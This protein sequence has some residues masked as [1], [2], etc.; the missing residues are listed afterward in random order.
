MLLNI[1]IDSSRNP[2]SDKIIL[3]QNVVRKFIDDGVEFTTSRPIFLRLT[4]FENSKNGPVKLCSISVSVR[5]FALEDSE[6]VV[7]PW[8]LAFKMNILDKITHN[9]IFMDYALDNSIPDGSHISL[10]PLG[11]I[12]WNNLQQNSQK[13]VNNHVVDEPFTEKF[14][15]DDFFLKSFLEAR[16]NNALSSITNGDYILMSTNCN[17]ELSE[18]LYKFKVEGLSPGSTVSVVNTDLDLEIVRAI[19]Y[20]PSTTEMNASSSERFINEQIRKNVE[21]SIGDVIS[22]IPAEQNTVFSL[23]DGSNLE[24]RIVENDI[25]ESGQIFF[26]SNNSVDFDCYSLSSNSAPSTVLRLQ[27]NIDSRLD[28]PKGEV[29]FVVKFDKVSLAQ[30]LKFTVHEKTSKIITNSSDHKLCSN[31]ENWIPNTTYDLHELR[32]SRNV[33]TCIECSKKFINV[34]SVPTEHWHCS[35]QHSLM[36]GD[37]VHSQERHQRF[38]HEPQDCNLC[39]SHFQSFELMARHKHNDCPFKEHVCRFCHLSLLREKPTV[40][41]RYFGLSGH[42]LACGMKTTECY[43]CGKIVKRMELDLHLDIHNAEK[44]DKA[45]RLQLALCKNINCCRTLGEVWNAQSLCDICYGQFYST[46]DDSDG[47]QFLRKLERKYVIQLSRGCGST[48][49]KNLNCKSSGLSRLSTMPEIMNH[50]H[51]SLMTAPIFQFWI[52]VDEA[53]TKKKL[54]ADMY[55]ELK[56]GKY[57]IEWI[58]YGVNQIPVVTIDALDHWLEE[59]AIATP[60]K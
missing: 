50:V 43:K 11:W 53:T 25:H 57:E 19:K 8:Y 4:A 17:G 40:E 1:S 52:C 26:G 10:E 55:A 3:S 29:S 34:G 24:L 21:I 18:K 5:E 42:E 31:C 2:F 44:I 46:Q 13:Y 49:C 6:S 12:S 7:I 59:N 15:R 20:P 41:S 47:S 33:K 45:Q 36:F 51:K 27:T 60:P 39:Q 58:H 14:I 16:L 54:V 48:F 35:R 37:T 38:Y 28:L 30:L 23:V 32:C 22:V 9:K 56:S